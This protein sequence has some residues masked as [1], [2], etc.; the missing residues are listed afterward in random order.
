VAESVRP[1]MAEKRQRLAAKF[2]EDPVW[3]E[4]DPMRLQQVV[5]NLL[6]NGIRYTHPGGRLSVDLA[7]RPGCAV[8]TVSDTGRGISAEVLPH[9]FE[10]FMRGED[11]PEEGL[12]V[13]L[14]IA[15]Q[16][17]ELHGGTIFA[18]SA[19]PGNGSEFVVSLPARPSRH[20]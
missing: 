8:L 17:V 10:P 12:G 18:S 19:G 3:I 16:F 2:P 4:G 15:R 6:L 20:R 9:I 7:L 11:A 1:Q 14:A 13:G 5:S